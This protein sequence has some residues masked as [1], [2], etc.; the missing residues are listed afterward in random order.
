[1][2]RHFSNF[3]ILFALVFTASAQTAQVAKADALQSNLRKHVE[4]LASDELEGRRT[5]TQGAV[6]AAGYIANQFAKLKLKPGSRGANG[7]AGYLQEFPY[8]KQNAP[9]VS[10]YNV[11]GILDGTDRELRKEAIVIGAHYDHLGM[12]GDGSLAANSTE[13]HHG[14]DD[15][16]SGTAA[17]I[18]LARQFAREKKNKR[19]IIFIAFSGEEEGLFGSKFYVNNPIFPLDNTVA[20]INLDMVG[21]LKDDK[22]TI[23]GVGTAGEW[24]S[25]LEAEN[26]AGSGKIIGMTNSIPGRPIYE[27]NVPPKFNLALNEDGFGPS[28][29]SSFYTKK[30]PVL[31]FFTGT[32]L[33][34][35]KP[36]DTADKI[37]YKG[38]AK[39]VGYIADIAHAVDHNPAR[40][41]YTVAKSVSPTG[42]RMSFNITL[43]T[44]PGYSDSSDGMVID[45]VRDDSPA[46]RAG[47]KGNDK[48]VMLA[49]KEVK[50]VQDY[51]KLLGEMKADVEY[52]IVV[53]RGTDRLTLKI[54]PVKRS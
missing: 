1:M 24:R 46:S 47:L 10:G 54:T 13:V 16:A 11:I 14:A 37:N 26:T 39:I 48:I 25:I 42:G 8:A 9:T 17:I 44:I 7:K 51:T 38:Q 45:G 21:R 53:V 22:L 40:P 27:K 30:I 41:T 32:H 52:E 6:A 28:D 33:D 15:N 34:Y 49:G 2:K 19:T 36:T 50:N 12:G 20:M 31:F 5:G 4:Y 3:L 18:E 23:G 43:G 35:H 29:H